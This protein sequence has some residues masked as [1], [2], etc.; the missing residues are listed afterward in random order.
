MVPSIVFI[1]TSEQANGFETNRTICRMSFYLL[2]NIKSRVREKTE[3]FK[4]SAGGLDVLDEGKRNDT[5]KS[6]C[7]NTQILSFKP[8]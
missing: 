2:G 6:Y 4:Q 3:Q 8:S 5:V 7:L 1:P